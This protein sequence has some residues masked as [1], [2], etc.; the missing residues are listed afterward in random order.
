MVT[1]DGAFP[2]LSKVCDDL[3]TMES[4]VSRAELSAAEFL[5]CVDFSSMDEIKSTAP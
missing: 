3:Q 5:R 2:Y 1:N 4:L